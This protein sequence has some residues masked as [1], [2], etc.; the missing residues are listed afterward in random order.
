M[1]LDWLDSSL[2]LGLGYGSS[3]A[4]LL[5]PIYS[6]RSEIIGCDGSRSDILQRAA[7]TDIAGGDGSRSNVK[8]RTRRRNVIGDDGG[9]SNILGR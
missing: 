9:R 8:Q 3:G 1:I 6:R 2:Y 5:P 7:T 4:I